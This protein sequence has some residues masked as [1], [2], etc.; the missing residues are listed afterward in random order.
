[1]QR[2]DLFLRKCIFCIRHVQQAIEI[3]DKV[4]NINKKL[5]QAYINKGREFYYLKGFPF[6]HLGI[7]K[8]QFR[9][10]DLKNKFVVILCNVKEENMVKYQSLEICLLIIMQQFQQIVNYQTPQLFLIIDFPQVPKTHIIQ[11][12]QFQHQPLFQLRSHQ[13]QQ[14]DKPQVIILVLI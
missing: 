12:E 9:N 2:L 11:N 5:F 13:L 7:T 1:M 3:N 10:T 14:F 8:Q 6:S 4:L